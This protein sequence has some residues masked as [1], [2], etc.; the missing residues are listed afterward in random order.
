MSDGG[1]S[2]ESRCDC[3]YSDKPIMWKIHQ[4][5]LAG[6]ILLDN[7]IILWDSADSGDF[8][9]IYKIYHNGIISE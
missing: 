1:R 5:F 2:P 7:N 3:E 6:I 8:C 4:L 9:Y